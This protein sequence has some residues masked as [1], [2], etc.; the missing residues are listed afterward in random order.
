MTGDLVGLQLVCQNKW[1]AER[2]ADAVAV[3]EKRILF[4]I[5]D[6]VM[7]RFEGVLAN[8]VLVVFSTDDR[9]VV[10]SVVVPDGDGIAPNLC[11]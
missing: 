8:V 2:D 3:V 10:D 1:P 7:N 5:E 9:K 6:D 4:V 11:A